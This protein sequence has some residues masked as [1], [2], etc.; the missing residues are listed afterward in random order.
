MLGGTALDKFV[1]DSVQAAVKG[2]SLMKKNDSYAL[3]GLFYIYYEARDYTGAC[4]I[5]ASHKNLFTANM[6]LRGCWNKLP[7][8]DRDEVKCPE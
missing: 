1:G 6:F 4:E 2:F 5:F 7:P 8:K 3:H